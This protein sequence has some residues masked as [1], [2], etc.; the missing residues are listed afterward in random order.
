MGNRYK[1]PGRNDDMEKVIVKVGA[2]KRYEFD[3]LSEAQKFAV[4]AVRTEDIDRQYQTST[5]ATVYWSD[6]DGLDYS[7]TVTRYLDEAEEQVISAA[8]EPQEAQQQEDVTIPEGY[9][10]VKEYKTERIQLLIRPTTKAAL[11]QKAA[12]QGTSLNDLIN[13]ILDKY[14]EEGEEQA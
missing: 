14:T 7:W 1:T 8:D 13:Q 11:K 2:Y 5:S 6:I 4:T 12:A 9:K 10:L 3:D